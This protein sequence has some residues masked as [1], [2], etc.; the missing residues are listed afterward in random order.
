[1]V[2][3]NFACT[4]PVLT[5]VLGQ[6]RGRLSVSSSSASLGF[7]ALSSFFQQICCLVQVKPTL[8]AFA[9]S[10]TNLLPWYMTWVQDA[11][12]VDRNCLNYFWDPVT[13]LFSLVPLFP[14]MLQKEVQQIEAIL[15][16]PGWKRVLWWPHLPGCWF[17][18]L[19]GFLPS[20]YALV[21]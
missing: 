19:G 18:L 14:A 4:E 16:C 2:S 7:P 11:L 17:S 15:I 5:V 21:T 9:T 8:G 13:W 20:I 3:R 10:I 1:M 6:S 12:S